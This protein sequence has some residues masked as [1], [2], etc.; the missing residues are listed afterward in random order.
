MKHALFTA[1]A[2]ALVL[3]SPAAAQVYK[4]TDKNG[5]TIFSDTACAKS[6]TGKQLNL[7][8]VNTADM[9]HE[10]NRAE[11]DKAQERIDDILVAER[12]AQDEADDRSKAQHAANE[13]CTAAEG[14]YQAAKARRAAPE[15]MQ[16]Q[17]AAL[18]AACGEASVA[19]NVPYSPPP[20]APSHRPAAPGVITSCDSGGCWGSDGTRYNKGAGETYFPSTGGVCQNIGG[21]MQ[22]H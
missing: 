11:R 9:S 8:S 14:E 13:K 4:C 3:S 22:C 6:S 21:M 2:A 5:K 10:R 17:K 18:R 1:I 12:R 20:A 15:A 16:R 7:G 19:R